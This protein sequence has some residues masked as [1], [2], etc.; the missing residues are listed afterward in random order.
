MDGLLCTSTNLGPV[1]VYADDVLRDVE[2]CCLVALVQH[3]EKQVEA[4]HD[5]RADLLSVQ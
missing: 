2:V 3:N 5:R 4:A 1:L